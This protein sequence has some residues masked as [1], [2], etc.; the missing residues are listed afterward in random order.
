MI[1][2]N[3]KKNNV[4]LWKNFDFCVFVKPTNYQIC[5]AIIDIAA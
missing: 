3:L 5:D 2:F 4:S 1:F